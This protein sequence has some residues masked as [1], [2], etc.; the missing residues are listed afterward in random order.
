MCY[1]K[2]INTFF[3]KQKYMHLLVNCPPELSQELK[4]D[5]KIQVGQAVLK[6][7]IVTIFWL[8]WSVT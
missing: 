4:N 7:L 5:I 2:I 3:E 1:L 8:V 6:L